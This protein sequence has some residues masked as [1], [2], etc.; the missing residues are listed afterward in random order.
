MDETSAAL[1]LEGERV[2]SLLIQ[3]QL[4][5]CR[6]EGASWDFPNEIVKALAEPLGSQGSLRCH[7][8]RLSSDSRPGKADAEAAITTTS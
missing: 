2:P 5:E 6:T 1:S 3:A 8:K 4:A 7:I